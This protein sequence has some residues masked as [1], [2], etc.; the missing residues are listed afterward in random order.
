[1]VLGL[2]PSVQESHRGCGTASNRLVYRL[3]RHS[4]MFVI[5]SCVGETAAESLSLGSIILGMAT[6]VLCSGTIS[7]IWGE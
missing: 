2:V 7:L 6:L 5:E 3:H 4:Q 1:M